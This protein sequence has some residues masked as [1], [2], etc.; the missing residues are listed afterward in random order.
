LLARLNNW[1]DGLIRLSALIGTIGLVVEVVV[2]L[3]DVV[4]R[5]FGAPLRGGQDL[6]QMGMVIIVFGGM[7]LCDKLG[8]HVN[9]DLF[10]GSMPRWMIRAGDIVSVIIGIAIFAG[11]AWTTWSSIYLMRFQLG[12]V[13]KT[14]IINLQFDWFKGAIIVLSLITVVG[15]IFKLIGL[16]FAPKGMEE[17][18]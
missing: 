14:N 10:E 1:A 13:Q 11:I 2:I 7:A 16:V 5:F 3:A 4:G 9:V 18:A 17:A 12:V 8:G 6:T 15:M